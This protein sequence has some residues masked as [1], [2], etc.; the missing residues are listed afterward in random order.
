[1]RKQRGV[2]GMLTIH[3]NISPKYKH[4]T[5]VLLSS[6]RFRIHASHCCLIYLVKYI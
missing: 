2:A 3:Y 5:V 1:M 6:A 4:C